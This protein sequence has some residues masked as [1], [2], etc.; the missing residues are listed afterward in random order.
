MG[1]H[2]GLEG[3]WTQALMDRF[4]N[5]TKQTKLQLWLILS[6]L[7]AGTAR[8][9]MNRVLAPWEHYIDVDTG[10]LKASMGDLYPRWVGTRALLFESKNPYSPEVSHEIQMAFYGH[11]I[12]QS[13]DQPPAKIID[14]QRFAYPIY[15]AFVLAPAAYVP[16]DILQAW[17]PPVLILFIAASVVLWLEVLRWRPPALTVAAMVVI[18]LASPQIAQ[19]LRLRQLGFL[20]GFLLA[21]ATWCVQRDRLVTAGVILAVSTI[22]PQMVLLPI[23]WFVIW[24]WGDA[25][26]RWRLLAG[27]GGS[28]GILIGAGEWMVP[29]WLRDFFL[30]LAA[31]RKYVQFPP[32]L[33]VALG[34]TLGIAV[35]VVVV[36]GLL[37]LAWK[38]RKHSADSREFVLTLSAF[39]IVASLA[40]PLLPPFNQVLLL[41][42]LLM[43]VRDWAMLPRYS[44]LVFAITMTWPWIVEVALLEFP[45]QLRSPSRIPLLPSSLVLLVPLL[46]PLLLMTRRRPAGVPIAR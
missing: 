40:L 4:L 10:R 17:A 16:F 27:F 1:Y 25:G 5:R 12:I 34:I 22:K 18:I 46:V 3:F 32:L 14:E 31:Y 8:L 7:A 11:A 30:G 39:L 42:P 20:V 19:G 15:V 33:Q 44:R 24:G 13:Y 41:L 29:G 38:N 35:T 9:Y 21:L 28:L 6:L 26:K 45:P 36:A 2:F 23:A 43:I 37:A